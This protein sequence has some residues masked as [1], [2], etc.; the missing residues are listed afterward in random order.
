MSCPLIPTFGLAIVF[1]S[2][3]IEF[4]STKANKKL[5]LEKERRAIYFCQDIQGLF[6]SSVRGEKKTLL[7]LVEEEEENNKLDFIDQYK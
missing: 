4:R 1:C 2:Q 3:K 5:R 6:E 7:W